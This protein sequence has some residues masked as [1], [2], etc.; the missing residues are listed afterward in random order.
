MTLARALAVAALSVFATGCMVTRPPALAAARQAPEVVIAPDVMIAPEAAADPA[1]VEQPP[2][3]GAQ[4]A[5]AALAR[6]GAPYR[7]GGHGPAGYDCSG[8]VREVYAEA[9]IAL[10]RDTIGQ[11]RAGRPLGAHESPE[12][13]DL[14]FFRRGQASLHVGIYL[15][16]RQFVHAAV[17]GGGVRIDRMDGPHW[18][19]RHLETRRPFAPA[20][21][22]EGI[23]TVARRGADATVPPVPRSRRGS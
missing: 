8:L 5:V 15:G 13:G 12:P 4:A 10:P 7:F 6:L 21:R 3:P 2:S 23:G 1:A 22:N 20:F 19:V 17:R 18:R 16:E 9:G 14:V 11:R